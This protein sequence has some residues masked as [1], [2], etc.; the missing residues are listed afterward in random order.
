M[1]KDYFD[2]LNKYSAKPIENDDAGHAQIVDAFVLLGPQER[3]AA[4]DHYDGHL[5]D[6]P[7]PS[8]F[9]EHFGLQRK[10]KSA[11]DKLKKVGR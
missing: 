1:S 2:Y 3:I 5:P 8:R 11:H 7:S 10:L 4:L 6:D 9:A